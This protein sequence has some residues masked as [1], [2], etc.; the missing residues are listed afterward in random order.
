MSTRMGTL[1][2]TNSSALDRLEAQITEL[3]GH[4]NAATYRFLLLVAEFDRSEAYARHGLVST[5][6]WL[7]WQC[8]IGTVAAREKVRVARALESLPQMSALFARG[9]VSYSKVRAMTRVATAANE[10]VLVGVA[11]HGTAAHIEKLVR[12]YRWV[13][14]AEAA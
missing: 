11:L 1:G 3:W 5:A 6:Q 13:E 9:E 2:T 12:K 14:R 10:S 4:L 7:N 8:G